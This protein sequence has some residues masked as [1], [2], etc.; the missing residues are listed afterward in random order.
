MSAPLP[1]DFHSQRLQRLRWFILL[2]V[3]G[4]LFLGIYTWYLNQDL[5]SAWQENTNKNQELLALK[6]AYDSLQRE[7]DFRQSLLKQ[8]GEDI[9]QLKNLQTSLR[10]EIVTL[11]HSNALTTQNYKL[12][13]EKL[14]LY[15]AELAQRDVLIQNM[16]RESQTLRDSLQSKRGDLEPLNLQAEP[17][18][19]YEG[20]SLLNLKKPLQILYAKI[21]IKALIRATSKV[22]IGQK[23]ICLK[24]LSPS[25]KLLQSA[26][27]PH[28]CTAQQYFHYTQTDQMLTFVYEHLSEE[29]GFFRLEIW[30]DELLIGT[31]TFEV[32]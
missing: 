7:I 17:I 6:H 15:E 29:R 20:D 27:V 8:M 24:V 23:N 28:A 21:R 3:F 19:L 4:L 14:K 10:Q 9:E 32:Q 25:G 18:M 26:N 5:K 13:K 30:A 12:L 31:T 11:T 2:L 1:D 22:G 16:K